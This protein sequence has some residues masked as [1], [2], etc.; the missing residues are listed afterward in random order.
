LGVARVIECAVATLG[1]PQAADRWL[2]TPN[3][4]LGGGIP[5]QLAGRPLGAQ[6]VLDVLNSIDHGMFA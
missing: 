3:Q 1:S 6:A 5:L 2:S 4:A